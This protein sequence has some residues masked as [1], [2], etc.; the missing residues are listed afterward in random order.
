[1][2]SDSWKQLSEALET[3]QTI[4]WRGQLESCTN[5]EREWWYSDMQIGSLHT[6]RSYNYEDVSNIPVNMK[7]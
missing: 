1:M 6:N 7:H 2:W 4:D 3:C 5:L